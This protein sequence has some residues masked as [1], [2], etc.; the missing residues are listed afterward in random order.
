MTTSRVLRAATLV[1]A[2]ASAFA[3]VRAALGIF[4]LAPLDPNEGWNAYHAG[5]ALAGQGLYPAPE[6]LYFNNYPPLSFHV[7]GWLSLVTHDAIAAGRALSIASFLAVVAATGYT[8][9]ALGA[10]RD[11]AAFACAFLAAVFLRY[12]HYVGIDDPQLFGHAIAAIGMAA[13]LSHPQSRAAAGAGAALCACALFVKPNLLPLPLALFVWLALWHRRSVFAYAAAGTITALALLGWCTAVYGAGFLSHLLSPRTYSTAELWHGSVKWFYKTAP[14]FAPLA[15][16][17]TR[18][19]RDPAVSWC[20]IYTAVSVAFGV[21]FIGGAGVDQNV[22][23]DA[24]IALALSAALVMQKAEARRYAGMVCGACYLVPLVVS[25]AVQY[26]PDTFQT[27]EANAREFAEAVAFVRGRPGPAA[28]EEQSLC[29]RA[30]KPPAVDFVNI[31]QHVAKGRLDERLLLSKIEAREF[32]TMQ[33]AAE[34]ARD[35]ALGRALHEA[36]RQA[37]RDS[38]GVYYVPLDQTGIGLQENGVRP[39]QSGA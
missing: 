19:A 5:A 34:P 36:Y 9:R 2:A 27:K 33:F 23:F 18:F 13:V 7:V 6:S 37:R 17:A 30:G 24:Y 12:S 15:W 31:G 10:S 3:L 29:Y 21:Y 26:R 4:A 8:A 28:C 25:A 1:L 22:F 38:W 39:L 16:L 35:T 14:F 11:H 20:A 32:G